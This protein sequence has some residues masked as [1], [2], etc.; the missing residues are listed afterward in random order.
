VDHEPF[1][2]PRL[3]AM[4]RHAGPRV[5][6]GSVAPVAVFLLAL[7]YLG[8]AGAVAAGLGWC[9]VAI[10]WRVATGRRVPG[11]LVLGAVTL[12]ARSALTIATGSTFVYFLQPTLGTALVAFAFLL[13]V[14]TDRPLAARLAGDFCPI[15]PEVL[16]SAP[17]RRFFVRISLLW[18]AANFA[19]AL[20][21]LW[22]LLSQSVGVVVV[23]RAA[24]SFVVTGGAIALS[25]LWF[26]RS[27]REHGELAPIRLR[28]PRS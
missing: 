18:A 5:L 14:G 20:I 26:R 27:M 25:V 11:V 6:E 28:A 13:S 12:T 10:G 4:A 23:S 7:H 15:P 1:Q 9:Y 19:N 8:V 3:G 16:A 24:V 17:M 21:S 2:L 22:L